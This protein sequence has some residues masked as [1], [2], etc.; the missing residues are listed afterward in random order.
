MAK[1]PTDQVLWESQLQRV[2]R[3]C[4]SWIDQSTE[5]HSSHGCGRMGQ[6]R[7][8]LQVDV[9]TVSHT[10]RLK[11]VTKTRVTWAS[12]TADGQ[13]HSNIQVGLRRI[14]YISLHQMGRK[15]H[16]Y[17]LDF[18][19]FSLASELITGTEINAYAT[20]PTIIYVR[21]L[22]EKQFRCN[23]LVKAFPMEA[24]NFGA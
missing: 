20:Y 7:G 22:R 5:A 24:I 10:A 16:V 15:I 19:I 4:Q 3:D 6:L 2:V 13:C 18:V 11:N 21:G 17:D 8:F 12:A 9:Y 1:T 14:V 23:L